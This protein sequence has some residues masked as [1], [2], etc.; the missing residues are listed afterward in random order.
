[1]KLTFSQEQLNRFF[2][3]HLI[4]DKNLVVL[5]CSNDILNLIDTVEG[6]SFLDIFNIRNIGYTQESFTPDTLHNFINRPLKIQLKSNQQ[7]IIGGKFED[8][9]DNGRF[10]FY[11]DLC[12]A[13][14]EDIINDDSASDN[15]LPE[16]AFHQHIINEIPSDIAVF[17]IDR[18]YLFVNASVER[19]PQIR[20]WMIDKKDEDHCVLKNIPMSIALNRKRLFEKVLNSKK[21]KSWEEKIV[22]DGEANYYLRSF[23]PVLDDN[24]DVKQ[25]IRYGV[26]ITD[27]KLIE[28]QLVINEKRYRDLYAYSPA[29][30]YTHNLDGKLLSCN[31]AIL[32]ILGYSEEDIVNTD[33]Q[34]LL[35]A[36][37]RKNIRRDY[38]DKI[39]KEGNSKGIFRVIP[40]QG[41]KVL[42]L[43][44]QNYL[45]DESDSS[46]Y[47]IGF[48]QDITDRINTEKKLRMAKLA[49][50]NIAKQKQIFL[51]NMSHEIRTPI[52]GIL[53]LNKLLLKT[54][55]DA[56][57]ENYVKLSSESI[58]NLLIIINDILDIEKI[59]FGKIEFE[60]HPFNIS[61]K[62]LRTIQLFQ[63]KAK[64]KELELLFDNNVST[65]F[66]VNGDQYRFSQIISNLLSNAIKF[67]QA[68]SV[69]VSMNVVNEMQGKAMLEFSVRDTG[70]GINEEDILK[71]FKP[72]EQASLSITRKYGGTGLGLSICKKLIELLD[73]SINVY[74]QVGKGSEFIFTIPF[75]RN[76]EYKEEKNQ[77]SVINYSKLRDKKILIGEDVEL[78]QF[79]IKNL[80]ESWGCA[81]DVVDNGIRIIEM[82]TLS[83]YDIILMDIQMPV[84]DGLTAAK[85]IRG[86]D[87]QVKANIPILAFTASVMQEDINKYRNVKMN[88]FILKPYSDELLHEKLISVLNINDPGEVLV[89]VESDETE[90]EPVSVSKLY[91]LSEIRSLSR[92]DE[93]IFN[94]I[95]NMLISTLSVEGENIKSSAMDNDWETVSGIVHKIKTSLIHIRVD[96]LKDIIIKLEKNYS[97]YDLES[98]NSFV[99]ELCNTLTEI[100][101]CLKN[102]IDTLIE[103]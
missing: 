76:F 16:L 42:Y 90:V 83:D 36:Y 78:N 57:Q 13:T 29:L 66:V 93:K 67:T 54:K 80:L 59:G 52:N 1:M 72:F 95:I 19:D 79:L 5:S 62:V 41:N 84:M 45:V 43:Y 101:G 27:R 24:G 102:D 69:T 61:D 32:N 60:N 22:E 46:S 77:S 98:L 88:D 92:N 33:I 20:K 31:P 81:V 14:N 73:G 38:F 50:E 71:I 51:A 86:M 55:L 17:N 94:K 97:D 65:E 96:S 68:G 85:H 6:K 39:I 70:I 11:G 21:I 25:V 9:A 44:Y 48:S 3:Y 100:V 87:D 99:D 26:N 56:Q 103:G 64:E 49:T 12:P 47:V 75:E 34:N 89:N 30:I 23:Y 35:P 15:V 18:T 37:D 7:L 2:P 4:M 10:L 82:L 8:L 58:N 91:D 28:E 40:K 63:Y 53:G 74:S